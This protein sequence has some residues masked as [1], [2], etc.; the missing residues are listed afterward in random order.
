[1]QQ[2]THFTSTHSQCVGHYDR[3][4]NSTEVGHGVHT[5]FKENLSAGSKVVWWMEEHIL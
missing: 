4:L 1:M 3:K 2:E 5:K